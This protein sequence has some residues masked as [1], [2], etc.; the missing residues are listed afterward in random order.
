MKRSASVAS[1]GSRR[2]VEGVD[3]SQRA[4]NSSVPGEWEDTTRYS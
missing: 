1:G 3:G 2:G 4:L